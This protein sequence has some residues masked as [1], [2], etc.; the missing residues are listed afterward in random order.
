MTITFVTPGHID[1]EAAFTFGISAK[2]KDNAI[3]FFGT[4]IKY[5]VA[6]LLRTGH[7]IEIFV[8]GEQH[9]ISLQEKSHRGKD[10][11]IVLL[12]G[13]SLG[14]TTELGKLWEVWMAFRELYSNTLDENG[15]TT[16]GE[17]AYPLEDETIIKV[18]GTAIEQA[19]LNRHETFAEGSILHENSYLQ[20]RT[21]VG[22]SVFYRGIRALELNKPSMLQY[23]LVTQCDLTEDRTI[24]SVWSA[25]Y[26]IKQGIAK[27]TDKELLFKIL[28]AP[29][30]S[31]EHTID[32]DGCDTFSEEFISV[33]KQCCQDSFL[34][35]S[36]RKQAIKAGFFQDEPTKLDKIQKKQLEKAIAFLN[37]IGYH[38]QQYPIVVCELHGP[39]GLAKNGT[40]YISPE[41]FRTGTKYLAAAIFEEFLHL[42]EGVE[43]ESRRMQTTLFHIIMSMGEKIV[44]EPL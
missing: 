14:F 36:A 35:S 1:L 16:A 37:Q 39:L 11:K 4:G 17:Y 15:F 40:I 10:F 28:L 26:Y 44:G 31:Y 6:T 38:V 27:I 7:K 9:H 19:Y 2:G 3:G 18:T 33:V 13:K 34:N 5:A 23:N 30:G 25:Q 41:C 32:Y 8:G 24:K 29:E 43:D 12:D 21:G 22:N 42:S 20:I